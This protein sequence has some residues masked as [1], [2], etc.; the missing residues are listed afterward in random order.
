MV[1]KLW[2]KLPSEEII[3]NSFS[4]MVNNLIKGIFHRKNSLSA[5]N[6]S[7]QIS[8]TSLNDSSRRHKYLS[9]GFSFAKTVTKITSRYFQPHHKAVYADSNNYN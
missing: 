2:A 9:L 1:D 7:K 4:A 6:V 5:D 8:L 3:V